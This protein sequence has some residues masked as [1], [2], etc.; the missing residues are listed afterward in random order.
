[1]AAIEHCLYCF[2]ALASHL[3]HREPMTLS[4]VEESYADYL[5]VLT[6]DVS[7]STTKRH[8]ALERLSGTSSGAASPA[9]STS[10]SSASSTSNLSLQQPPSSVSTPATS[11]SS[12]PLSPDEK[13]LETP[14]FVTWNTKSARR[15][16]SLRGCIGTFEPQELDEG[17][18]SYAITSAIHDSRFSPITLREL[19]SLQVA[20]TL[21][22]NF[23][24][25]SDPMDWELGTHGIRISF[26]H[27]GRRYGAT[28]LPDVAVE[29]GWDKEE[30]IKSLMRKAG[31]VGS[32]S[33]WR[34]MGIKV[35]R[36]QGRREMCEYEE[37]KAWREWVVEHKEG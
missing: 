18:A 8:P 2:E 11:T 32:K 5:K 34:E 28:Y 13:I 19:P 21:L 4:E 29:Q 25:A 20:V 9:P 36:Y 10:S 3:E 30:T 6:A 22:T 35:V 7:K 26:V 1:M 31:Y 33:R 16:Y 24:D 37:F 27:H 17:L 14:L 15:G 23:E 12:L